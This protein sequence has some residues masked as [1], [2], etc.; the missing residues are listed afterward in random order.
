MENPIVEKILK[1][2]VLWQI[3]DD[4]YFLHSDCDDEE[5][6]A[7]SSK[8]VRIKTEPVSDEEYEDSSKKEETTSSTSIAGRKRRSG[9]QVVV[10]FYSPK[11]VRPNPQEEKE[12]NWTKSFTDTDIQPFQSQQMVHSE[13][14]GQRSTALDCFS[15]FFD[16]EVIRFIIDMTNLNAVRKV[17]GEG[18]ATFLKAQLSTDPNFSIKVEAVSSNEP[19]EKSW[20]FVDVEEM[21][22]FLGLN[23]L[24]GIIRLPDTG[25]YWQKK[26]CL[27]D[28]PSFNKI[29]TRDRF[30]KIQEH[31]Y[32]CDE[33]LA[34]A[35]DDPHKD[36]LFKIRELLTL[37]LPRFQRCYTPGR[38]LRI[39]E[40]LIP[41]KG[42]IGFRKYMDDNGARN[43]LKLWAVTESSTG[44]I[45][46]LLFYTGKDPA[47]NPNSGLSLSIVKYLMCPYEGLNHHLYVDKF[48]TSPQV[49]EYLL[50]KGIYACGTIKTA[51][52]G[53]P[54]DL[55][56]KQAC[57]RGKSDWRA[58]GNLFIKSWMFNKPVYFLSTI[59]R[60]KNENDSVNR[61][62]KRRNGCAISSFVEAPSYPAREYNVKTRRVNLS[63]Q[64]QKYGNI[65]K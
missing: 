22:A 55:V 33:S 37:L 50:S 16:P 64:V 39:S 20:K 10:P 57:Q 46:R 18:T 44:Y 13:E 28:I 8:K 65:V 35:E 15:Q 49:F 62:V 21:N 30:L 48:H 43:G 38:D 27:F 52:V 23:I 2:D 51:C 63:D 34:P 54:K 56:M 29:M 9:L 61:T 26:N 25:M 45:S 12:Y 31:L 32:F 7:S 47:V 40:T 59:H 53:F 36:K 19:S 1:E 58:A 42:K 60:P 11:K 3:D 17:Q 6:S 5:K 14:L 4:G 41:I 24:M